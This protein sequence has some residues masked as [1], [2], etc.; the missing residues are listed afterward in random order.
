MRPL[1]FTD[2][3]G[4]SPGDPTG[5]ILCGPYTNSDA[6]P[7]MEVYG[8]GAGQTSTTTTLSV[9]GQVVG[10]WT[11]VTPNQ[12]GETAFKQSNCAGACES[13]TGSDSRSGNRASDSTS[14]ESTDASQNTQRTTGKIQV[15]EERSPAEDT[16]DDLMREK[17]EDAKE[18]EQK[19]ARGLDPT[20]PRN[21]SADYPAQIWPENFGFR[22]TPKTS[23]VPV[24]TF[25][26]R[27]GTEDGVFVS[28]VGTSFGM[29]SLPEGFESRPYNIYEV[30]REIPN[31]R[32]GEVEPAFGQL[33]HGYQIM[34]P[35]TIRQL[36]EDGYLRRV[37]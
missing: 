30:V 2:T 14:T 33:G 34:L 26:D 17:A 22:G 28:P 4:N 16:Y 35:S 24:G 11:E 7:E 3:T 31:A 8:D 12:A 6:H 18:Q 20:P 21:P 23:P 37:K 27:V 13:P 19:D 9:N 15:A 25:V 5:C 36:E 1:S 29:R 10:Q 32:E